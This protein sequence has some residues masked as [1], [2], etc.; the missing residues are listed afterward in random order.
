MSTLT[1]SVDEAQNQLRD[2]L[3][4]ARRGDEVLIAEGDKPVARLVSV[5]T[6]AS[7]TVAPKRKRIAG[8]NRGAIAWVSEDF[9]DP[10]PDEFWLGED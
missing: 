5:E 4:M 1:I 7:E 3:A 10:L 9:D 2:L 8:L 6:V